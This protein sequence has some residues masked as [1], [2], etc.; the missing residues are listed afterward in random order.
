MAAATASVPGYLTAADWTTFNGKAEAGANSNITSL[1]G[2]TTALSLAQG[3]TGSN[4]TAINGGMIYSNGST[5]AVT[6][7]GTSGQYLEGAGA[8]SPIWTTFANSVWATVLTGLSV[9]TNTAILATD[10][11]LVALGKLQSQITAQS[12]SL[13]GKADLING[14]QSITASNINVSTINGTVV[15]DLAV[16]TTGASVAVRRGLAG[17]INTVQVTENADCSS[18]AIGAIARDSAGNLLTCQ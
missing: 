6:A 14:A 12:S 13:G 3:G 7:A 16:T 8:A 10:S 17:E 9:A 11:I 2:L 4:I 5:M 1:T 18:V 15:P